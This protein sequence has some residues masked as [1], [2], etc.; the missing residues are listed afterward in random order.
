[1]KWKSDILIQKK[2]NKL[3][4]SVNTMLSCCTCEIQLENTLLWSEILHFHMCICIAVQ[5]MCFWRATVIEYWNLHTISIDTCVVYS[6]FY[7][8]GL[9]IG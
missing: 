4:K 5:F 1:M 9:K 6:M 2:L 7:N 3:L 8:K